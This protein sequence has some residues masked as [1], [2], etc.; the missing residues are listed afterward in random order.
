MRLNMGTIGLLGVV[1]TLTLAACGGDDDTPTRVPPRATAIPGATA[2]PTATADTTGKATGVLNV[3]FSDLGS[4]QWIMRHASAEGYYMTPMTESLIVEDTE[5]RDL[6]PGLATEW[7][8]DLTSS[9]GMDWTIKLRKGV[10]FHQGWGEMKARD[11]KF[12]I[13]E[14]RKPE[15]LATYGSEVVKWFGGDPNNIEIVHDYE[16]IVHSPQIMVTVEE[17][18]LTPH[19]SVKIFP[20]AYMEQVG[21]DGFARQPVF[22]GPFEFAEHRRAQFLEYHALEEHW[23]VVPEFAVA[24]IVVVPEPSTQ[25]AMMRTGQGDIMEVE[26]KLKNEAEAAGLRLIRL[27]QAESVDGWFGGLFLKTNPTYDATVP[28]SGE[29]PLSPES[30]MVRQAMNLALDRQAIVDKILLGEG[31]VLNTAGWGFPPGVKWADPNL[32]PYPYDPQKARELLEQ[33]GYPE[34]FEFDQYQYAITPYSV[35]VGEAM[36]SYWEAIGLRVNRIVADYRPTVRQKLLDNTTGGAVY[37][38]G[39]RATVT[40]WGHVCQVGG[41]STTKIH[42]TEALYLDQTCTQ[43]RTEPDFEKRMALGREMSKWINENYWIFPVAFANKIFALSDKVDWFTTA[44]LS[45]P[46]TRLEYATH[47]N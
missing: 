3:L 1:A 13:A 28:W 38:H 11:V 42:H 9:G 7:K 30:V 25:L 5:T 24:K 45:R 19:L 10:E 8:V 26:L 35:D 36:A 39:N 4:E 46:T 32:K 12:S 18:I 14:F 23:R 16:L 37:V 40:P 21:D 15:S 6:L 44:A 20:Q 34:G 41:L 29:D 43:I 22:T 2:A 17:L 31:D 27:K 33:A 47:R